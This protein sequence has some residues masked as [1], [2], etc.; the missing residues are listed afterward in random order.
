MVN[1][2]EA[3]Y[4]LPVDNYVGGIEHAILHLLYSRFFHKLMRNEGLV[5]Y[6]EPFDKYVP[7]GMVLNNAFYYV[8]D[9]GQRVWLKQKEVNVERNEKGNIIGG[10]TLDGKYPVVYGGMVKMS[11][12]KNNGVSPKEMIDQ[13]G[14]D[15]VRL[16]LM[17]AAP[18]EATLEWQ[19]SSLEGAYRF[20]RRLWTQVNTFVAKAQELGVTDFT[21]D[22]ASLN[23]QQ[24]ALRLRLHNTIAKV[25][26]DIERRQ[27][28]NTAIAAIM[29]LMNEYNKAPMENQGD[30]AVMRE[31][32][33]AVVLMLH[34]FTPH[35]CLAAWSLLGE[36]SA[37]DFESFPVAD[38]SARVA[39]TKLIVVQVN[40]K[41]RAKLEVAADAD[42]ASV[43]EIAFADENVLK[44]L[45]GKE[46]AKVIYVPNKL[47]NI[48]VK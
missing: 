35:L 10:T 16:Y 25:S 38:E 4:W 34:P 5:P 18:V 11:K 6:D 29:E 48:V 21:L 28:F 33:R 1:R 9:E 2:E 40:G 41:L 14:A 37:I 43:R 46:P 13:Y 39:S 42:E 26:D 23:A 12:S 45:E 27:A 44:F 31:A 7:L 15:A 20:L 22:P 19:E 8:N 47:L 3:D 36:T 24:K 17:F 32:L 30:L